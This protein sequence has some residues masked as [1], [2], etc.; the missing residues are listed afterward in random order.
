MISIITP[1]TI[2]ATSHSSSLALIGILILLAL[3]VLKELAYASESLRAQRLGK[4]LNIA[5]IPLLVVFGQV[6][7]SRMWGILH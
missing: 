2:A 3:I 7:V 5:I 1:S 4:H 6:V